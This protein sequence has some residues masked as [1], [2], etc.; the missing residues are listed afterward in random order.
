MKL[1]NK[2]LKDKRVRVIGVILLSCLTGYI[3]YNMLYPEPVFNIQ[4]IISGCSNLNESGTTYYLDTSIINSTITYC[5][6][7]TADNVTL[8]C[9]G[10]RV[11]GIYNGSGGNPAGIRTNYTNITI[12]N[13]IVT[14]WWHGI[15]LAGNNGTARGNTVDSYV[16]I[17]TN[18]ALGNGVNTSIYNNTIDGEYSTD[19]SLTFSWGII[20][21]GSYNRVYN[22]TFK[23][24]YFGLNLY[25]GSDHRVY[26]N[27]FSNSSIAIVTNTGAPYNYLYNNFFNETYYISVD[28]PPNTNYWSIKLI[29]FQWTYP[30][31]PIT[32]TPQNRRGQEY[33]RLERK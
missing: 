30:P 3:G 33:I 32:G 21:S 11:D 5:L 9:Q 24:N 7:I 6:N 10:Y 4:T 8:N 16:S 26:L 22:N 29:I 31:T 28:V 2:T 15:E 14:D 20:L 18:S 27:K 19:Y 1:S 13:C 12:E 25:Q 17:T 23:D